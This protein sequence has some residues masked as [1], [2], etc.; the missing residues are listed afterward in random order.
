MGIPENAPLLIT[1]NFL[2]PPEVVCDAWVKPDLVRKWLFVGP[3]SE[4]INAEIDLKAEGKYSL[5]KLEKDTN[6][7][8]DHYGEYIEIDRPNKL[9]FSLFVPKHFPGELI[10]TVHI[11]PDEEGCKMSLVQTGDAKGITRESWQK[12]LEQLKLSLETW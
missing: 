4:I 6:E 5:L 12:M 11:E 7:Q 8:I 2:A 3:A 1:Y 10:I 9:V